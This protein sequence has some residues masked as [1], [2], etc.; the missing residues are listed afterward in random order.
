MK[1]L[2]TLLPLFVFLLGFG[3]CGLA[4]A[5]DVVYL[6][7]GSVIH[8]TIT[9]EVPGK[10]IKIE[11]KDGNVFVYKMGQIEKITHSKAAEATADNS[12]NADNSQSTGMTAA[13]VAPKHT[14]VEKNDPHARFSK[15]GFLLSV[16]GWAPGTV[17]ELN[18]NLEA[19]TGSSSYDYY[20]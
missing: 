20:P 11:T 17:K 1:G 7:D 9:E 6:K 18:D 2:K 13:P 14:F 5:E 8:G 12:D 3:I 15:F 16:G 10:K 19:G 4:K